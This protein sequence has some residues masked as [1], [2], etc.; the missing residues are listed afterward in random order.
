LFFLFGVDLFWPPASWLR[1][2]TNTL[3]MVLE[4]I[5]QRAQWDIL[6]Q[7][8]ESFFDLPPTK[9]IFSC[10]YDSAAQRGRQLTIL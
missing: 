5:S 8:E 4:G 9:A 6:S 7:S 2:A 3:M 10:L 1:Y